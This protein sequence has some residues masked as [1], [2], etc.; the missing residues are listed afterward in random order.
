M[1]STGV[2]GW[3]VGGPPCVSL[4]SD[5]LSGVDRLAIATTNMSSNIAIKMNLNSIM[6]ESRNCGTQERFA[7][8]L[9]LYKLIRHLTHSPNRTCQATSS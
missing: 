9:E 5:C 8:E 6:K 7:I 4:L 1:P 3:F 2:V